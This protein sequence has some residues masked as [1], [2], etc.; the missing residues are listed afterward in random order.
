MK[1]KGNVRTPKK[2]F[3]LTGSPFPDPQDIQEHKIKKQI[4]EK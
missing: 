4:K 1:P 3:R 2:P